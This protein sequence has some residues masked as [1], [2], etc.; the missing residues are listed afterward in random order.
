[1]SSLPDEDV[2]CPDNYRLPQE[3]A[4]FTLNRRHRHPRHRLRLGSRCH[5]RRQIYFR[6]TH[7]P[8]TLRCTQYSTENM[9]E[10]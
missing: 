3:R 7:L 8:R 1:M 2:I 5:R 10:D 6:H 9:F 4:W